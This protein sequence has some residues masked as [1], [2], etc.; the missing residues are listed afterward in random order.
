MTEHPTT[1][2]DERAASLRE[3][4]VQYLVEHGDART[5][6]VIAALR[7]VPRHL[8]P[9]AD[10]E[11]AYAPEKALVTKRSDDG[12]G[13]SSVSAARIQAMQLEEA[14]VR[15]GMRVLEIGSGG[16]NAAYLA[17]LVGPS[18]EVVTVDIDPEVTDRARQFLDAASYKGVT[19]VTG[20][21]EHGVP[22]HAAYDRIVVT[23]ETADIPPAWVT[24][25]VPD[26]VIVAPVRV[27][28]LTRSVALVRDGD[29]L[30]S[31][32]MDV[33]GFVP[34]RGEG[35]NAIRLVVLNDEP[36]AAVGLRVDGP[37]ELDTE[38]LKAALHG[39]RAERWTGVT[40]GGTESMEYLDMWLTTVLD[41]LPLLAAEPGARAAGLV[42]A[43]SPLGIP[44][45]VED[46]SFGYR[47][48]RPTEVPDRYELG[49]IAHGPHA[50]QV[51]ARYAEQI[52]AWDA[53]HRGDRP[54]LTVH[55][56]GD[57]SPAGTGPSRTVERRH[58]R[59]TITWP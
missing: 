22:D 26:G 2:I 11:R 31:R 29:A 44:A 25:L 5:P 36:G 40:I 49:V 58:S 41:P 23:V 14:D 34:M 6:S 56:T 37:E 38:G 15:P 7:A 28:G 9:G 33:C 12:V 19:V 59:F 51:A 57:A 50:D 16:V 35:E 17:E 3:Q 43:A 52:T 20:D 10:P 30:V 47:K 13:L 8:I 42:A 53:E 18:G 48:A 54:R 21:A 4:M 55:P 24:Q 1:S 32:S 46:D 27:R 45:L 39:G